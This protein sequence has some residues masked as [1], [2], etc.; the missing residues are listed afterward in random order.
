MDDH[1]HRPCRSR[2]AFTL[3]ELLVVIGIIGV[4]VA[5]LIPAVQAA[6][7]SARRTSCINNLRQIGI[8]LQSYESTHKTLPSGYISS[9]NSDGTDTGPGWGWAALLLNNIEENTLHARLNF[10]RPIEDPVNL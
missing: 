3:I 2:D 9:F 1:S 8:A 10:T 7:E 6:R 4:L 5:L